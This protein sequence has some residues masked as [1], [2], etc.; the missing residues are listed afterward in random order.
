PGGDDVVI[1]FIVIGR[2]AEKQQVAGAAAVVM[3]F[4]EITEGGGVGASGGELVIDLVYLHN[5][6]VQL[7]TVERG[8]AGGFRFQSVC[9]DDDH[10][11]G[12]AAVEVLVRYRPDVLRLR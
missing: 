4:H 12:T 8:E 9:G 2:A 10:V 7:V 5:N 1:A 3:H 6:N 11:R